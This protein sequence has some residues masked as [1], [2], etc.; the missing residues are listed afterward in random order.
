MYHH[1]KQLMYTVRVDEP[2][3]K[4]GRILPSARRTA[5]PVA[6]WAICAPNG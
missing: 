5:A 2:E 6:R 1:V 4:F 3:P